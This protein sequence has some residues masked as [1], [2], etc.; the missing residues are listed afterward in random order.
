MDPIDGRAVPFPDGKDGRIVYT[1]Y[2]SPKFARDGFCVAPNGD[3]YVIQHVSTEATEREGYTLDPWRATAFGPLLLNHYSASGKLLRKDILPGIIGGPGGVRVD[4][5]GNV[6]MPCNMRP[7]GRAWDLLAGKEVGDVNRLS[8]MPMALVKFGRQGSK[9]M[10]K[11]GG[12]AANQ[13]RATARLPIEK[14]VENT[15][16]SGFAVQEDGNWLGYG[17]QGAHVKVEGAMAVYAGLSPFGSGCVCKTCRADLD[18]FGRS[19]APLYHLSCVMAL[20]NNLNP[21]TRIGT[22]GGPQFTDS[23]KTVHVPELGMARPAY[24]AVNDYA[25]Y[26]ADQANRCVLRATLGYHIEE[27]VAIPQ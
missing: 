17:A 2:H 7:V 5:Q 13:I 27:T 23:G 1:G 16:V 3:V 14:L 19:F 10:S 18:Q 15:D 12:R 20:D 22:Y 4:R 25:L 11:Q 8:V 9:I 26:V 21:I 6:F 24:T